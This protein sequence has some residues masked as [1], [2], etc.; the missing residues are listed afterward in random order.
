MKTFM[1]Y[2]TQTNAQWWGTRHRVLGVI[3]Q[4]WGSDDSYALGVLE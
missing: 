2:M 1:Y 3:T 4:R